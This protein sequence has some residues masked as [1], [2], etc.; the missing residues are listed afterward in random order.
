MD[1]IFSPSRVENDRDVLRRS[2]PCEDCIHYNA[3]QYLKCNYRC[4]YTHDSFRE[5]YNYKRRTKRR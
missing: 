2:R 3:E 1:G 5:G 4:N